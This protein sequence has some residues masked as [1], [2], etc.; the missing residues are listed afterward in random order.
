MAP[1]TRLT[2]LGAARCCAR[3]CAA[4]TSCNTSKLT[5]TLSGKGSSFS[6]NLYRVGGKQSRLPSFSCPIGANQGDQGNRGI[7]KE[8]SLLSRLPS[9]HSSLTGIRPLSDRIFHPQLRRSHV[10]IFGT[11]RQPQK[12][13]PQLLR[14]RSEKPRAYAQ[15]WYPQKVG[16]LATTEEIGAFRHDV[17]N[18]TTD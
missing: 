1:S 2:Q 11:F 3:A 12:P 18:L 14:T 13:D 5:I 6:K 8:P 16:N 15:R 7:G 10:T 9:V 17:G 4:P